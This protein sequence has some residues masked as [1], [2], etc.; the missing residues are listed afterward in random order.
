MRHW[1]GDAPAA[2]PASPAAE[3]EHADAVL[4][5]RDRAGGRQ[6]A[7]DRDREMRVAVGA[8]MQPRLAHLEP[9][10]L[11]RHRLLAAEQRHDRLERLVHAPALRRGLDAEH[12]GVGHERARAAAEHRAAARHVVELHEALRDQERVVV[13]Q[14][15]HAGAEPDVLGALGRRGD[16]QLG[17]GDDLPAGGMVLADPGLVIAEPV[18]LLDHL[19]DRGRWRASGCRPCDGT[20]PGRCRTACRAAP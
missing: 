3:R 13:R 20:G 11:A 16:D 6:R 9:V 18:E 1:P 2:R 12:V 7:G 15:G 10:R 19:D 8:Q 14:A 4:A 5:R 17:R